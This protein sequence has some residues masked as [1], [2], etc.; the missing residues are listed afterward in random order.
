MTASSVPTAARKAAYYGDGD[1][2]FFWIRPPD[3]PQMRLVLSSAFHFYFFLAT[4]AALT[5]R[6]EIV[7]RSEIQPVTDLSPHLSLMVDPGAELDIDDVL[8]GAG[9]GFVPNTKAVP[10]F[11][12]TRAAIWMKVELRSE[13]ERE[14]NY[15]ATLASA[16]LSHFTWYAVMD[17]RVVQ[18]V[19]C[20]SAEGGGKGFYRLPRIDLEIPPGAA[21][22]LYA[23]SQSDTSQWLVM[24]GGCPETMNRH[25][26]GKI[27]EVV[28]EIRPVDGQVMFWW[29]GAAD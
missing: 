16:R 27:S 20:G 14:V 19:T 17:G 25:L 5:A 9:S 22:T 6:G 28:P 26:V 21:V 10:S 11:G 15:V 18:S 8:A 2:T 4:A 23:R 3:W 1:S 13:Y 7:I 29:W 12:F 24:A